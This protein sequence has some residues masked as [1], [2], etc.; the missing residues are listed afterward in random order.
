M[1]RSRAS[2]I[3]NGSDALK[4]AVADM[5]GGFNQFTLDNQKPGFRYIWAA[6]EVTHPQSVD[7]MRRIGYV[8]VNDSVTDQEVAPFADNPTTENGAIM[9][10]EHVLMRIPQ[11]IADYRERRV[12]EIGHE[13]VRNE[14]NEL[15]ETIAREGGRILDT[16]KAVY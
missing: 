16:D 2:L 9:T 10:R 15:Q 13:R 3:E 14:K 12:S 11:E 7:K 8:I 1:A 5:E 4:R 6:K